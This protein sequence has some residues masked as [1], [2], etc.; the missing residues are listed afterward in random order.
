[1]NVKIEDILKRKGNKVLT[2]TR[3]VLLDEAVH[4]MTSNKIGALVVANDG[5]LEGIITERDVLH[6]LDKRGF[7]AIS[8][9]KVEDLMTAEVHTGTPDDDIVYVM[10]IMSKNHFRHM[11]VINEDGGKLV[12]LVSS[13]DVVTAALAAESMENRILKHYIKNWP[14]EE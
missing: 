7:D 6:A 11:P 3:N 4:I 10:T 9:L 14:E 5:V 13:K 8:K 12:G 2:V 1:M